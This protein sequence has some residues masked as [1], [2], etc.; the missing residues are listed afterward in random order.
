MTDTAE[1]VARVLAK[2]RSVY[3]DGMRPQ[4]FWEEHLSIRDREVLLVD[5]AEII[6]ALANSEIAAVK[7]DEVPK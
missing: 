4:N 2:Q 6:T 1:L 3:P 7:R 5:A